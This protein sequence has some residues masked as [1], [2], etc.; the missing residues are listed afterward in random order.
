LASFTTVQRTKEIGI[1]KVLGASVTGILKL[2][3]KEFVVLL[4]VAFFITV[5]LAWLSMYAWLKNYAFRIDM[6]WTFFLL[7]FFVI[8]AVALV[9]V[10][11][12]SIKAAIANPVMSLRTE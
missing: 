10:S 8:A 3:Y 4:L 6:Q 5:P 9:T 1:R 11:F 7:P 2:L 12:Q